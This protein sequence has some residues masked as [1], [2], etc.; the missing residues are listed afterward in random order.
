[1]TEQAIKVEPAAAAHGGRVVGFEEL[2]VAQG[3]WGG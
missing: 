2:L 1:M 3:G